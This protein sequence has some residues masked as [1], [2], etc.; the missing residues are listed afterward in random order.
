M[1][2]D[3]FSFRKKKNRKVGLSTDEANK[4]STLDIF[5]NYKINNYDI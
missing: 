5:K 3:P 2:N 1:E 4:R